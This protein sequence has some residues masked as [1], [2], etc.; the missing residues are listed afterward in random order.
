MR[1][2]KTP[3]FLFLV[4]AP[5]LIHGGILGKYYIESVVIDDEKN[6]WL[7]P[8]EKGWLAGDV[9]H[10]I[11]IDRGKIVW[12]FG[13]SF[14]GEYKNGNQISDGI[15]INNCIAIQDLTKPES[16]QFTF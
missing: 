9:G 14:I 2:I 12:L 4:L 16:E 6:Q 1:S 5:F 13:D 15:H 3:I 11:S 10:S 8:Q 7:H